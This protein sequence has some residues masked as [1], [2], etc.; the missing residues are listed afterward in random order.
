MQ[1]EED[2]HEAVQSQEEQ[3]EGREEQAQRQEEEREEAEEEERQR[4]FGWWVLSSVCFPPLKGGGDVLHPP[5]PPP[6]TPRTTP[7]VWNLRAVI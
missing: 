2:G 5:H 7:P 1:E 4:D 6:Y 3:V